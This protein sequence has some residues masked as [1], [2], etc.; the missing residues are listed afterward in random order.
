MEEET[1]TAPPVLQAAINPSFL[2]NESDSTRKRHPKRRIKHSRK[3]NR[4]MNEGKE[5]KER[6]VGALLNKCRISL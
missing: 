6:K 3:E 4:V 2:R 1:E 5:R